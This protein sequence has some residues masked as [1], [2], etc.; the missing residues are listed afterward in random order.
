MK[1]Q[2]GYPITAPA[3]YQLCWLREEKIN[4]IT[5]LGWMVQAGD[6]GAD[7][8]KDCLALLKK[9][10]SAIGV[11]EQAPTTGEAA[12]ENWSGTNIVDIS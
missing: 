6:R 7:D 1:N 8:V 4:Q 12:N 10:E 11:L 9:I 2:P 5:L 3:E